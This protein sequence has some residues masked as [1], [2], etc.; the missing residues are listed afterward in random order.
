[1]VNNGVSVW[2]RGGGVG[3][4]KE[5]KENKKEEGGREKFLLQELNP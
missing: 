4:R 1:M 2:G 5:K 3:I